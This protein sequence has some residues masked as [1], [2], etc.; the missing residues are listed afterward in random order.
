[1]SRVNWGGVRGSVCFSYR[2]RNMGSVSDTVIRVIYGL[3]LVHSLYFTILSCLQSP[4]TNTPLHSYKSSAL[5]QRELCQ[6]QPEGTQRSASV[7]PRK[8]VNKDG[9][10]HNLVI[11]SVLLKSIRNIDECKSI[12][13]EAK[14][15]NDLKK[16]DFIPPKQLTL[17]G[18]VHCTSF[19][20]HRS[21][22]RS[23]SVIATKACRS[24]QEL[25]VETAEI[26][27][28]SFFHW[29]TAF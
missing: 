17:P 6:T 26:H 7:C 18:A 10:I 5:R 12:R 16:A 24:T 27:W 21:A 28:R 23:Q 14:W 3:T 29:T 9:K 1:M 11:H 2:S 15:V 13:R 19:H 8:W 20:K 25:S 4:G 22:F